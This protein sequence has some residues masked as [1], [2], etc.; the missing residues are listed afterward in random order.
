M[1]TDKFFGLDFFIEIDVPERS[2][3]VEEQEGLEILR[4]QDVRLREIDLHFF[5][6]HAPDRVVFDPLPVN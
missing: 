3:R 2:V 1:D 6:L 5:H 4:V